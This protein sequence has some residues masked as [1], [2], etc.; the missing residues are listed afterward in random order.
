MNPLP[1]VRC[2]PLRARLPESRLR[3]LPARRFALL[4]SLASGVLFGPSAAA[5]ESAELAPRL[6][7]CATCHGAQGEGAEGSEY[8]PHLAGKPAQYLYAQLRSFREGGRQHVQMAWLVRHL[9]DAY[10]REIGEF[11]AALPPKTAPAEALAAQAER[12]GDAIARQLVEQG[13]AAR[14]LHACSACH[15][16]DLVGVEPG[17]PALVGLPA[18]YVVAQF[19][20]WRTGVRTAIAPDCMADIANAL[21]P[22]EMR[23]IAEW[24]AVQGHR[25]PRRPAPAGSLALPAACGSNPAAA[26]EPNSA[27]PGASP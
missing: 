24:L 6:A 5:A 16:A 11:Y 23:A 21:T 4:L 8:A 9:D 25:E 2:P 27:A 26:P 22:V 10:L 3:A 14:G 12:P 20:A 15:G 7:A 17:V 18:E 1:E 19:G 13:D